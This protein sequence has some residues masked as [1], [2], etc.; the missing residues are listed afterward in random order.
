M[1]FHLFRVVLVAGSVTYKELLLFSFF[2]YSKHDKTYVSF[3]Y[4]ESYTWLD[5]RFTP[6][7]VVRHDK[8]GV[9]S[10]PLN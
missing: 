9:Y 10:A 2:F 4:G 7:G 6:Q 1:T 8:R 5:V 3:N